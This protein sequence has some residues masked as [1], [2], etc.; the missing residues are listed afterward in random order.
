MPGETSFPF[1]LPERFANRLRWDNPE[2]PLVR[3]FLPIPEESRVVPGFVAEPLAERHFLRAPGLLHKYH[4]RA[5]L[6]LTSGCAVHCRFCFRRHGYPREIPHTLAGWEP[7][8]LWLE[9][10]AS[11]TEIIFSGGDPWILADAFLT[12]LTHRLARI[13]HLKRLRIHT[14]MPVVAPE[15]VGEGLIT[16]LTATRLQ[17]L[18]VIHVNHPD[19]LDP[20]A[21]LAL[22]RLSA[23][24]V[25]LFSQSVL[26]RGVNDRVEILEKLYTRLLD[27]RVV[28][29]YLHLLDPVAGSAHFHIPETEARSLM[30]ALA[31]RLP[32]YAV[33]RLAREIP[34]APG[35]VV[36]AAASPEKIHPGAESP[37]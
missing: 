22:A 28:P 7:A 10:E 35:K 14:R 5:M 20:A 21:T 32:G 9:R 33:P 6:L 36:L 4:G 11:I 1:R 19:E 3:Q 30:V 16:T 34:G 18:V 17:P 27:S 26:L 8:C 23:A 37:V 2:D 12:A 29:Y 25:S 24:G 13:P 15:R 31:A